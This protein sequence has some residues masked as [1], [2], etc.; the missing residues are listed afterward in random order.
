MNSLPP[1]QYSLPLADN[2]NGDDLLPAQFHTYLLGL[3]SGTLVQ[4]TP[5]NLPASEREIWLTLFTGLSNSILSFPLPGAIVWSAGRERVVLIESSLEVIRRAS[6]RVRGIFIGSNILNTILARLL[7]LCI[8]FEAWE[9]AKQVTDGD[10]TC[11]PVFMKE[12]AFLVL[13]EILRDL[14][15]DTTTDDKPLWQLSRS[16]VSE[17]L[18]LVHGVYCVMNSASQT[19]LIRD[20]TLFL[21]HRL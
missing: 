1:S 5:A 8:V 3:L 14:G 6:P 19:Y 9:E 16:F 21:I 11:T 20:Q 10:G 13:T 2:A 4:P 15:N 17:C 12:K 7:D 18:D